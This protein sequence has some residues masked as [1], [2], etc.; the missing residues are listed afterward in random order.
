MDNKLSIL[1]LQCV[2]YGIVCLSSISLAVAS[3][4]VVPKFY[5]FRSI[6]HTTTIEEDR[7]NKYAIVSSSSVSLLISTI[8]L[9]GT[10]AMCIL[11][12]LVRYK[13]NQGSS[14][15]SSSNSMTNNNSGSS[16]GGRYLREYD[17][18]LLCAAILL[19]AIVTP[20][21]VD[22]YLFAS[23]TYLP[24]IVYDEHRDYT[25][26]KWVPCATT[27]LIFIWYCIQIGADTT[28]YAIAV[29]YSVGVVGLWIR[30]LLV[31]P[32]LS[33]LNVLSSAVSHL[34]SKNSLLD[35]SANLPKSPPFSPLVPPGVPSLLL[36]PTNRVCVMNFDQNIQ[37][38]PTVDIPML[39]N[40]TTS[41]EK[42]VYVCSNC[43]AVHH[44]NVHSASPPATVPQRRSSKELSAIV[45]PPPEVRSSVVMV[46]AE[47]MTD[48]MPSPV[49]VSQYN[50]II[51]QDMGNTVLSNHSNNDNTPT[52]P[53]G[54]PHSPNHAVSSNNSD[55]PNSAR[56]RTTTVLVSPESESEHSDSSAAFTVSTDSMS[57]PLKRRHSRV[58]AT[59][60]AV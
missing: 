16:S 30:M 45:T 60:I 27:I 41:S 31:S 55:G 10:S 13:V 28:S 25:S 3:Y 58:R 2:Q 1:I 20:E 34:G 21:Y 48:V 50:S 40:F 47:V 53:L 56:G 42:V 5:D 33:S 11:I 35:N 43:D 51:W 23:V 37:T 26:F 57:K 19:C 39:D 17:V 52:H 32:T 12:R 38:D 24:L 59:D 6:N 22:M 49:E 36:S 7:N 4:H 44:G 54:S 46:D 14:S 9:A 29:L 15:S 18:V 8:V